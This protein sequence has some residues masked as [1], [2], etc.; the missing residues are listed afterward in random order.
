MMVKNILSEVGGL[1]GKLRSGGSG[2]RQHKIGKIDDENKELSSFEAE[3]LFPGSTEAWG[4]IVPGTYPDYPFED[5]RVIIRRSLW[6][7]IGDKLHV[8]FQEAPTTELMEWD[9]Q[10]QD[11]FPIEDVV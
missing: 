5:P 10:R 3:S 6:F 11:W 7:K 8:A 2:G 9:A 1:T 4:E